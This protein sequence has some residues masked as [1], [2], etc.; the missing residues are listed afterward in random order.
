[1]IF[2]PS[3][4]LEPAP[5]LD[6]RQRTVLIIDDDEDQSHTLAWRLQSQG[7]ETLTA[8]VGRRG[9]I[10]AKSER[11]DVVLLDLELPDIDGLKICEQLTDEEATSGIPVVIIS[12]QERADI[13]RQARV[14]GCHFYLRKPYDPN[15]VLMVVEQ[16]IAR[17]RE[18]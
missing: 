1:M 14:A 9:L 13:V 16:A 18:W 12:G 3:V 11:P 7:F 2:D 6:A 5:E 17:S 8:A 4:E 10:L 15:V